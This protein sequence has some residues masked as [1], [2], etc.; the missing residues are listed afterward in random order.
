MH[1][2]HDVDKLLVRR[3]NLIRRYYCVFICWV[4]ERFS[5]DATAVFTETEFTASAGTGSADIT[6]V[7]TAQKHRYAYDVYFCNNNMF[8]SLHN[9]ISQLLTIRAEIMDLQSTTRQVYVLQYI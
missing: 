4:K 7:E 9:D 8:V 2:T 3:I 5:S 6:G 1:A